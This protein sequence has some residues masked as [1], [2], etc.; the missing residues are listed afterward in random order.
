VERL[1]AAGALSETDRELLDQFVA[2]AVDAHD[3]DGSAAMQTFGGE[4]Q[5]HRTFRGSIVM[6]PGGGVSQ[7]AERVQRLDLEEGDDI[8]AVHELPGR[9]KHVTE[10]ARGGMGRVL[11][12]HDDQFGWEIPGY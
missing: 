12:A 7:A 2:Q 1:V 8:A 4:E 6:T 10:Y 9:Y 11:L 3:G 5:V